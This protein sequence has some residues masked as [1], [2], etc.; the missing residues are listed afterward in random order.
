M[1]SQGCKPEILE[2]HFAKEDSVY[3]RV[4][5]VRRYRKQKLKTDNRMKNKIKGLWELRELTLI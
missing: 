4:W 3:H 5:E 1:V 2:L